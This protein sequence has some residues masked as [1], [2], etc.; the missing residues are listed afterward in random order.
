PTV[1]LC[2]Q[3]H[4]SGEP[5][6]TARRFFAIVNGPPIGDR[7]SFSDSELHECKTQTFAA[8]ERCGV[9]IEP[10]TLVTTSPNDFNTTFPGDG[11]A[12]YG[13]ATHGS[14]ASFKRPSSRTKIRGVYL[15]GGATHPGAGVPNSTQSGRLAAAAVLED[16]GSTWTWSP[17]AT[18]GGISTR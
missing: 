11:G 16:F 8:L 17:G 15:A 13:M 1:Y 18:R 12:I 7:H 14:R 10:Q 3:D 5:P 4:P 2:S 9:T 6:T